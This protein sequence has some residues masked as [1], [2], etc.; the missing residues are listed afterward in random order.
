[1]G[2]PVL[3]KAK[4]ESKKRHIALF[5]LSVL[6]LGVDNN[7]SLCLS[8]L[9]VLVE[10]PRGVGRGLSSTSSEKR[11]SFIAMLLQ[12]CR[13]HFCKKPGYLVNFGEKK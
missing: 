6:L 2:E 3:S 5:L 12:K 11:R 7:P 9:H 4:W 13:G 8:L 1:M 10:F